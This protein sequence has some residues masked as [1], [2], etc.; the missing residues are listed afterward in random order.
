MLREHHQRLGFSLAKA[1]VAQFEVGQLPHCFKLTPLWSPF[2]TLGMSANWIDSPRMTAGS[3]TPTPPISINA[4]CFVALD[5]RLQ[6]LQ[7]FVEKRIGQF[8]MILQRLGICRQTIDGA[9]AVWLP[10]A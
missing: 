6:R 8:S 4:L 9:P 5:K 3:P 2:R 7:R 1:E 10:H